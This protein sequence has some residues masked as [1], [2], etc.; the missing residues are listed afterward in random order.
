M[1]I[2]VI[3][4]ND[5]E[6]LAK[7][8]EIR[9][10][11]FVVEQNCPPELEYEYEEESHHFLAFAD[12]IPAG[13]ARWRKTKK[14]YKLERFAVLKEFRGKKVGEALLMAVLQ[15]VP[16]DGNEIYLHA[17]LTAEKFYLKY[18]FISFGDQ[19]SEAGIDHITMRYLST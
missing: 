2:K 18:N 7:V 14:G 9:R 5:P 6:M 19:F 17:Q 3:S 13:A 4:V 10:L 16:N 15:A 1:M 12:Q 11:V 8:H